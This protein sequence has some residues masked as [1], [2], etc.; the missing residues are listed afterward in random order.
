MKILPSVIDQ[1]TFVFPPA[2]EN[3]SVLCVK[4]GSDKEEGLK[5]RVRIGNNDF[6]LS[7]RS[8]TSTIG[9]PTNLP[10]NIPAIDFGQPLS[11]PSSPPPGRQ[12]CSASS[13]SLESVA[14]VSEI[15]FL[16]SYTIK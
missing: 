8:P 4:F 9:C 3:W 14:L 10:D 6:L 7:T 12:T 11:C 1:L 16:I 5:T 15:E 2:K 13:V